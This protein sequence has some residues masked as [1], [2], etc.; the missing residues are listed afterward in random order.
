V[1]LRVD[2][3]SPVPPYEQVRASVDHAINAV[4]FAFA[5]GSLT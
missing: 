4:R 2:Q 1:I 5:V 3:G